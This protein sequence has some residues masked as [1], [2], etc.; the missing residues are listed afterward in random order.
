MNPGRPKKDEERPPLRH[1]GFKVDQETGDALDR[2]VATLSPRGSL[3]P[4]SV[5]LR[6]LILEKDAAL[7][8]AA[9]T[10]PKPARPTKRRA[11]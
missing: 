8:A 4:Q 3:G 5:V 6:Q 11:G 7:A 10:E 2:V 9:P 1:I